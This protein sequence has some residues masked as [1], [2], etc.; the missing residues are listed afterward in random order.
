[1]TLNGVI[2]VTLRYFTEFG[3]HVFQHITASILWRNLCASLLYFVLLVRCRRKESSRSLSHLL[4]SFLLRNCYL[5]ANK[6]CALNCSSVITISRWV[7]FIAQQVYC[8]DVIYPFCIQR[9][10]DHCN[11][12]CCRESCDTLLFYR[13]IVNVRPCDAALTTSR[14][15][16]IS[17]VDTEIMSSG[18][19]IID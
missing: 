18:R 3:K 10:D 4:M 5:N 13:I 7:V 6:Y 1:M 2:A 17:R 12:I 19:H 11:W 16:V 15:A 8:R 9:R 14:C